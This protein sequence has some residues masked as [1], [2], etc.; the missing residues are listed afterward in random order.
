MLSV[1]LTSKEIAAIRS[2]ILTTL[3]A[4][5]PKIFLYGSRVQ[6]SLTGGDIDLF[7]LRKSWSIE[8]HKKLALLLAR[9]K[10]HPDIG[11][12][13]INLSLV[14]PEDLTSDPFWKT[15]VASAVPL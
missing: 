4:A 3:S 2:V 8:D 7:V 1:R 15:V 11:D 10:M 5:Q 6:D 12:R 13:K 9:L 14:T